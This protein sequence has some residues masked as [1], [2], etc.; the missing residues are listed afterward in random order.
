MLKKEV[1][2]M[3]DEDETQKKSAWLEVILNSR[4]TF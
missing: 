3:K 4:E 2:F 1:F